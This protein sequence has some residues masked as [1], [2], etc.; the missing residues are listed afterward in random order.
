MKF[1]ELEI[2]Q[3]FIYKKE[4]TAIKKKKNDAYIPSI[5]SAGMVHIDESEEVEILNDDMEKIK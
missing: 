2:G 4:F 3:T 5:S 1:A